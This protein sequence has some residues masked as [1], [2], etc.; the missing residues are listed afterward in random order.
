MLH[1]RLAAL[2]FTVIAVAICG[3]GGSSKSSTKTAPSAQVESSAQAGSTT[4]S[5][6][7]TQTELIAKADAV[8]RGINDTLN[9]NPIRSVSVYSRI[10]P[11]EQAALAKLN[12]FTVPASL[13]G[14]WKKTIAGVRALV[15][16]TAK[17]AEVTKSNPKGYLKV[18][19]KVGAES[20]RA[21]VPAQAAATHVGLNDCA[22]VILPVGTVSQ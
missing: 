1:T 2:A 5:Q 18:I 13:A 9:S 11:F 8:C 16:A 15:D 20:L 4:Q 10:V 14:E 21:R 3:C 17:V 7:L 12:S 19:Q 6:T 22:S